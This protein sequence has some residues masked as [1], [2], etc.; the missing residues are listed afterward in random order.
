MGRFIFKNE[1]FGFTFWISRKIYY[2]NIF[3]NRWQV[4][5]PTGLVDVVCGQIDVGFPR[6]PYG[7]AM[8][9]QW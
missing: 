6:T 7:D 9:V 4:E 2:E 3:R 1:D 5:E 8:S